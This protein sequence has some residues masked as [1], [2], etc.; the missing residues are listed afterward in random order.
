M[1]TFEEITKDEFLSWYN[2]EVTQSI[3]QHI[4]QL[5]KEFVEGLASGITLGDKTSE[6]TARAVGNIEG[7]DYLLNIRYSDFEQTGDSEDV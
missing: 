7:L 3:F 6:T 1:K 4:E 2:Q 5:R